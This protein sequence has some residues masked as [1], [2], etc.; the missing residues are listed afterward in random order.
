VRV[1]HLTPEL[2]FH[3]GSGGRGHEFFLCRRLVELGHHVLNI[4]PAL[5]GEIEWASALRAAGV[6]NWVVE[7]PG[8]HLREAAGAVLRE[9]AVLATAIRSPVRALE[10]RIFWIQLRALVQ[11]A[12]TEWRPDVVVVGHDMAAAWALGVPPSIPAVLAL[13]NL[14]WRWYLS[15]ALA[16]DGVRADLLRAEARRYRR[17]VLGLLPRFSV[18]TTVSPIEADE[19][20]RLTPLPVSVI[21]VGVDT[22]VLH[23]LPEPNGPPTLVF[24]GSL[25][26]QPNRQ[27]IRWFADCVWPRIRATVPDAELEVVGRGAPR[28]VTALGRRPGINVVGEVPDI[29]PHLARAHAVVV[30]ILTGAGIRVKIVEAMSAGR[31]VVSTSLGCEGMPHVEADR[32]LLVADEPGQFAAQTTRLLLGPALRR[33]IAQEARLTAERFYDWRMLGEQLGAVLEGLATERKT[34]TSA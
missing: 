23:P 32:Q 30:P 3:P 12:V 21:P 24:T 2:P 6:E 11:R 19:L 22:R 10:M 25:G 5:P 8:S 4:S 18:A 9:P 1:L 17:Y 14:T 29:A 15:R 33:S 27:G 31:A 26:Y 20:R 7:R 34:C 16:R 28:A 13:H